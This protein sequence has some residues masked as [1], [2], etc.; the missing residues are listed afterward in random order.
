MPRYERF[1]ETNGIHI[2][3][4]EFILDRRGEIYTYDVNT[5]TNYNSE[6]EA[7]A[8]A[9]GMRAIAAYLG[10]ELARLQTGRLDWRRARA[11]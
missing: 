1:L 2:A 10:E 6:A 7:K 5:N 9:S 4:I 8:G 3:G 11:W